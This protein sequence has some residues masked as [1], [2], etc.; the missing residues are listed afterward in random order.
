MAGADVVV[1]VRYITMYN[2]S[3][4]GKPCGVI[5]VKTVRRR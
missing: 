1:K 5:K 3:G 2:A 4:S